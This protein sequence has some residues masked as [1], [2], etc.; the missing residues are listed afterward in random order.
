M[1]HLRQRERLEPVCTVRHRRRLATY[2]GWPRRPATSAIGWLKRAEASAL[3]ATPRRACRSATR[4]G[5]HGR[6]V[7][8]GY[9]VATADGGVW[10]YGAPFFG[11]MG[12]SPLNAPVVGIAATPD[13]GGYWLVASDGGVFAFGDAKFFGSVPGALPPG[14]SLNK[15]V[16]GIASSQDGSATGWWPGTAASSRSATRTSGAPWVASTSTSRW[17]AWPGNTKGGYWLVARDGGVFSFDATFYGSLG[18][19]P[20]GRPVSGIG[21]DVGRRRL[22][23]DRRGRRG[24]RLR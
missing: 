4:R 10:A 14:A 20:L 3:Q 15:P 12:A 6:R 19:I 7:S 8:G 23:D 1:Q 16:V 18:G 17:W 21:G 5:R 22:L 11:S 13:D 24:L 9:W 2:V